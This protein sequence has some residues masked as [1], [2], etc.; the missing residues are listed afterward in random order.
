MKGEWTKNN[1]YQKLYKRAKSPIRKGASMA[2]YNKKE[3]LYLEK[4]T[5]CVCHRESLL[6]VRDGM[7]VPKDEAP[8]NMAPWPIAFTS[9][10]LP[11]A[12]MV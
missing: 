7:Q 5:S 1:T 2:I 4:D 12:N 3:Q 10:S 11:S 8:N 9:K 6:Q